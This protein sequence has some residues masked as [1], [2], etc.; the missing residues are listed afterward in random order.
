[1]RTYPVACQL[2]YRVNNHRSGAPTAMVSALSLDTTSSSSFP[3]HH[4]S[5][6]QRLRD[7]NALFKE[8][9]IDKKKYAEKKRKILDAM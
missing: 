1:M 2:C 6:V 9:L 4:A 7:L 3:S 8:G 5:P